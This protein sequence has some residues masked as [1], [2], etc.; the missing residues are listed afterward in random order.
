MLN[1][2]SYNDRKKTLFHFFPPCLKKSNYESIHYVNIFSEDSMAVYCEGGN[3]LCIKIDLF[4][5]I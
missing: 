2:E 4:D 3:Q 5:Q 1:C